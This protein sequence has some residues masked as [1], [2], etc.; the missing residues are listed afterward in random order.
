MFSRGRQR[1]A[2][3][4]SPVQVDE[5]LCELCREALHR[6]TGEFTLDH[7]HI[8]SRYTT[9]VE[10][11]PGLAL[12][13]ILQ[14]GVQLRAYQVH[15]SLGRNHFAVRLDNI[16]KVQEVLDFFRNFPG[17]GPLHQDLGALCYLLLAQ[18]QAGKIELR[19]GD[20][21]GH[22]R[23]QMSRQDRNF[24][25]EGE[26]AETHLTLTWRP[27][28]NGWW[29]QFRRS[30]RWFTSWSK[31]LREHGH[32]YPLPISLDGCMTE[33]E[34]DSKLLPLRATQ[35]HYQP[36]RL[37]EDRLALNH[38]AH[39]EPGGIHLPTGSYELEGGGPQCHLSEAPEEDQRWSWRE[40]FTTGF[41]YDTMPDELVFG[42]DQ[43][44]K[45]LWILSRPKHWLL[46]RRPVGLKKYVRPFACRSVIAKVPP[47][48][49]GWV[50]PVR[51]G[52]L[53]ERQHC[54]D[55]PE[56]LVVL[57]SMPEE[58]RTDLS[59]TRPVLDSEWSRWVQELARLPAKRGR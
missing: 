42:K 59:G 37:G 39:W 6:S 30:R 27:R 17:R 7:G 20:H 19:L 57:A 15:L 22:Q 25:H 48:T 35:L 52:V 41:G 50:L 3:K 14:L 23:L 5:L 49:G 8:V 24:V 4:D 21:L 47:R 12:L 29:D 11:Q 36:A 16:S 58:L 54:D 40:L 34:L 43:V 55:L 26:F 51:H 18:D 31:A 45:R 2:P 28:W 56:D 1:K 53:L 46:D 10:H 13:R 44:E 9:L 32:V 33:A 38:P